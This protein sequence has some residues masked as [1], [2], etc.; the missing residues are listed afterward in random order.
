MVEGASPH[1]K[2]IS[3]EA[4]MKGDRLRNSTPEHAKTRH[5]SFA[6]YFLQGAQMTQTGFARSEMHEATHEAT[7]SQR[8]NNPSTHFKAPS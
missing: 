4:E 6:Q 7:I 2:T 8:H 1:M 3:H 5:G